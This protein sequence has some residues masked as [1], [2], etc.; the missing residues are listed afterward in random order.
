MPRKPKDPNE[1]EI[2]F[3]AP[4]ELQRKIAGALYVTEQTQQD[5]MVEAVEFWIA[6]VHET[7]GVPKVTPPLSGGKAVSFPSKGNK[8]A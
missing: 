2:K 7:R 4:H 8:S 6:H 5:A 3:R 1:K